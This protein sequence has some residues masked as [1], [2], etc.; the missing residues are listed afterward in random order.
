MSYRNRRIVILC[1]L[2]LTF[3]ASVVECYKLADL[4]KDISSKS[5]E[6]RLKSHLFCYY[7]KS[8]RPQIGAKDNATYVGLVFMPR[9]I[10]F[11]SIAC[12]I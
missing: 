6:Y 5:V 1:L 10:S 11:V 8:V 3:S 2:C 9:F 7:D 12:E 4:C